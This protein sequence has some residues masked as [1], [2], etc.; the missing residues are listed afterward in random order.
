MNAL[1]IDCVT[2][3]SACDTGHDSVAATDTPRDSGRWCPDSAPAGALP[4]PHAC[5]RCALS[6]LLELDELLLEISTAPEQQAIQIFAA[7]APNQPF[8]DRMG[9]RH[10]RH[11]LDFPDVENPQV[12]L[13]LMKPVPRIMVGT[14]VGRRGLAARRAI[15]HPAQR[16]P[17]H[18]A[19]VHAE[20]D[21]PPCPVVHH[22]EY[23][24]RVEDD[25]FASKQI[26]TPQ[27][28]LRVSQ[29][30]QP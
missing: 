19:T 25:R 27:T 16:H 4:D 24:V 23:P 3:P 5:V 8:D 26:D 11:R 21:N 28:V 1:R 17:V 10:V 7:Y 2:R 13:P 12:R 9:T 6:V 18:T 14:E 20:T 15:E 29:D 22:D 30:S